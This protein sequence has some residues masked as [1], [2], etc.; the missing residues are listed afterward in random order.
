MFMLILLLVVILLLSLLLRFYLLAFCSCSICWQNV[1][2]S[3]V[4]RISLLTKCFA[5]P[6][7]PPI[8][9]CLLPEFLAGSPFSKPKFL[10]SHHSIKPAGEKGAASY[11]CWRYWPNFQLNS[12]HFVSNIENSIKRLESSDKP[13]WKYI[14]FIQRIGALWSLGEF[15]SRNP[16][17]ILS[18]MSSR[19]TGIEDLKSDFISFAAPDIV[20][21]NL[22][23]F[24]WNL[25]ILIFANCEKCQKN[26]GECILKH[27]AQVVLR[28]V[29]D[30]IAGGLVVMKGK[31]AMLVSMICSVL[32]NHTLKYA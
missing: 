26:K 24:A 5:R 29:V 8:G 2:V 21:P 25:E 23:K 9:A 14:L 16:N 4:V 6:V 15:F 17:S 13:L 30:Y 27:R 18:H 32:H 28:W 1:I 19:R 7:K 11:R 10:I 12:C 3:D 20:N 22:Q 31:L